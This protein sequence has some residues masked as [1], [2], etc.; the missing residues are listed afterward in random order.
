MRSLP[1]NVFVALA[2]AGCASQGAAPPPASHQPPPA[3]AALAP[4]PT[5]GAVGPRSDG[6]SDAGPSSSSS[7]GGTPTTA[8]I[9]DGFEGTALDS[10]RWTVLGAEGHQAPLPTTAQLDGTRA[11]RGKQ[12]LHIHDGLIETHPPGTAFYGRAWVWFDADPGTGHWMSWIGVGPGS[13]QGTEVRYGG[14]Y[15]I[16]EANYFGNDDEVISDPQ[17]YCSPTCSNGVAMPVGRW[18]CVEF[19]FGKDELRFWLDG[20][21][22]PTL[23]VTSWRNQPAPWSPAYDRVRLGFHDFQGQ[24]V[25][26]WYDDV[27]LDPQRIGCN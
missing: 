5:D 12:S 25:D 19:Y 17:G 4:A 20:N 11:H 22:V 2:L 14:H 6:S 21:E 3:D 10:A 8:A 16:L 26:V 7:D 9:A 18:S 27:A 1:L 23:H 13:A 15:D 24:A